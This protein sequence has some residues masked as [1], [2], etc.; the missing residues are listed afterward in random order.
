MTCPAATGRAA[1]SCTLQVAQCLIEGDHVTV[2]TIN[3][4]QVGFMGS[5]V[6]ITDTIAYHDNAETMLQAIHGRGPD[7]ST[8]RGASQN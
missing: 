5:G 8:R 3:I 7:T 1:G 4:K 2:L 6:T